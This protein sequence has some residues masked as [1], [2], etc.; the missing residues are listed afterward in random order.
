MNVTLKK[1]PKPWYKLKDSS[2]HWFEERNK[3]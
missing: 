1:S 2:T 3:L